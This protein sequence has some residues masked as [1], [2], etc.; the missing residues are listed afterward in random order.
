MQSVVD[1]YWESNFIDDVE[2]A[3]YMARESAFV[4]A[5]KIGLCLMLELPLHPHLLGRKTVTGYTTYVLLRVVEFVNYRCEWKGLS[6]SLAKFIL[7]DENWYELREHPTVYMRLACLLRSEELF[8]LS[9]RE[10]GHT[11]SS[12]TKDLGNNSDLL[13]RV[14]A[15]RMWHSGQF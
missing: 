2:D 7:R 3:L 14:G 1:S 5:H 15:Y 9:M 6:Q 12:I 10:F 11:Y 13:D 8:K 4:A